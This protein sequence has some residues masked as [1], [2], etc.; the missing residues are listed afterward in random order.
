[1]EEFNQERR[2]EI[3]SVALDISEQQGL[4]AVSMRA[5]ASRVGL[6]P[7][8]LYGYFSSK[9]DLLDGLVGRVLQK[10]PSP[11]PGMGWCERLLVCGRATR[12]VAHRHPQTFPL[13]L[14]RPAVLPESIRVVETLYAALSEAGL[15]EERI[16]AWERMLSTFVL[17]FAVSEVSGRFSTGSLGSRERREQ[18]DPGELPAHHRLG[19]VLDLPVDWDAEFEDG[20]ARL[21]EMVAREGQRPSEPAD[22]CAN[23]DER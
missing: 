10:V 6:T 4:A 18:L 7:M 21:V 5:I 3:L 22:R 19:E 17:G 2:E 16:A 12:R 8:A 15:A 9:D 1:M 20:L 23:S 11:D 14:T 13:L